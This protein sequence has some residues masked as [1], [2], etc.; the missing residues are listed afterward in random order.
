[1]RKLFLINFLFAILLISSSI[2]SQQKFVVDLNNRADDLF[3]VTLYPEKLSE[4]NDIF[5]FAATAPGTYETMDIGRFV[6]SFK[7]FD[8]NGNEIKTEQIS[9]NQWQLEDPELI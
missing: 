8:Q 9:T 3:K 2:Y 1:M 5:Q 4:D 6:R 7:A